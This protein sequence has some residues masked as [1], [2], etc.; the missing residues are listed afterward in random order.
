MPNLRN[1]I[2]FF[3]DFLKRELASVG[4]PSVLNSYGYCTV[5]AY[6]NISLAKSYKIVQ[7]IWNFSTIE[8]YSN[9]LALSYEI[10]SKY[11]NVPRANNFKYF[12]YW[13]WNLYAKSDWICAELFVTCLLAIIF[14]IKHDP[15]FGIHVEVI[16][17]YC[18]QEWC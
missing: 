4:Y 2:D 17:I 12:F 1:L 11:L 13:I 16:Q 9:I 3:F 8:F 18:V 6:L 7:K 5:Q 10:W 15:Q 14:S